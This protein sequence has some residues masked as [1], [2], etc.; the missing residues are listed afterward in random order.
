MLFP[1]PNYISQVDIVWE[2]KESAFHK[3]TVKVWAFTALPSLKPPPS[4]R[5][6]L[7]L[8]ASNPALR[9]A[10][11]PNPDLELFAW[12]G[13]FFPP[14][15]E[16]LSYYWTFKL[17]LALIA[18]LRRNTF[19]KQHL[20]ANLIFFSSVMWPSILLGLVLLIFSSIEVIFHLSLNRKIGAFGVHWY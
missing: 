19:C 4:T 10:R 6:L 8:P 9:N 20:K 18:G 7:T 15:L 1:M 16:A 5:N 13:Y 17:L 2:A 14:P 3:P 12:L 11:C